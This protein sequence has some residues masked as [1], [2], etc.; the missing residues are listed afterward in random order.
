M[1]I[2]P[3]AATYATRVPYITPTEFKAHPTGVDTKNLV[4]GGDAAQNDQALLQIIRKASGYADSLAEKILAATLDTQSGKYTL[5]RD[6]TVLIPLDFSP[7]VAI[8]S[9]TAG[10]Q[11]GSQ[12]ALVEGPD[13]DLDGRILTVP[14]SLRCGDY[15]G[16]V[17][18]TVKYVNGWANAVLTAPANIGTSS[19]TVSNGLGLVPGL[20]LSLSGGRVSEFVVIANSYVPS[21]T[22]GPVTVPL[23][24]P[25]GFG[26]V[27]GDVFTAIPQAVKLA[28]IFLT[29]G[30]IKARGSGGLVMASTKGG[31]EQEASFHDV[32]GADLAIAVDA[33]AQY[34]RT[35]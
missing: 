26:Y 32:S 14:T 15:R 5:Q 10:L 34:R 11:A 1:F 18:A 4:P 25:L 2:A 13:W 21:V 17:H 29:A 28:V 16:K 8:A 9:V 3:N 6:G 23:A 22:L 33:L 20:S 35:I 7:I 30:I 12:I 31:P 24:A 27:A 19:L